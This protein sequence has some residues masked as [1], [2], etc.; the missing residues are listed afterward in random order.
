MNSTN[1]PSDNK[2]L[3]DSGKSNSNLPL[4]LFKSGHLLAIKPNSHGAIII[5]KPFYAD[6]VGPGAA[7]G[8]GFD[9]NCI[10]VYVIGI[11]EFYAPVTYPERQQAFHLRICYSKMLQKILEI[12][13]PIHRACAVLKRLAQGLGANS[14]K[15]IPSELIAQL[16][17][18][19]TKTVEIARQQHPTETHPGSKISVGNTRS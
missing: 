19:M 14:I 3:C 15:Q 7:V 16:V 2:T 18:V 6:F 17:G 9:I 1:H 12:P 13:S 5:Q 8:G 11:V 10:S 4:D